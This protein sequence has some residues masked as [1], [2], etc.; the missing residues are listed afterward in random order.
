MYGG[1]VQKVRFYFFPIINPRGNIRLAKKFGFFRNM[2]KPKRTL[3]PTQYKSSVFL[4]YGLCVEGSLPWYSDSLRLI[5]R[6][7]DVSEVFIYLKKKFSL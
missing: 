4:L 3:W 5:Y 7:S 1:G 6:T 2:E